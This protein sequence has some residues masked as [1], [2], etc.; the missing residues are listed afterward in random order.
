MT[1][2]H[3]ALSFLLAIIMFF[4][5][6]ICTKIK[7]KEN[8]GPFTIN[9]WTECYKECQSSMPLN[10]EAEGFSK[11][12]IKDFNIAEKCIRFCREN[13]YQKR[14]NAGCRVIM[15]PGE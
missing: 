11:Q 9:E 12:E 13:L 10:L 4:I 3:V 15:I 5:S 1:I 6:C 8:C 14:I 2:K 7:E